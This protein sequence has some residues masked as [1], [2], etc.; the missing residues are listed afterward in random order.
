MPHPTWFVSGGVPIPPGGRIFCFSA[1]GGDPRAFLD[2]QPSL[3]ADAQIMA[4]CLPGRGPRADEPAPRS[5]AELADGAA[6]AISAY[7]DRPICL[8]GHSFGALVAFEVA[9]RL[10]GVS[11][12]VHHLV[13]SG[14]AA[15]SLLPTDY[16]VWAAANKGRAFLDESARF[17]ELPPEFTSADED[18]QELLLSDFRTDLVLLAEYSYIRAAP[19]ALGVT[20]ICGRDDSYVG[21]D[22]LEPWGRECETDPDELWMDGDH[23]FL[24]KH[25]SA[26]VDVLRYIVRNGPGP[27]AT[28][29]KDVEDVEDVEVI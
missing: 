20:L 6:A 27:A 17:F 4:V 5:I 15:P 24:E 16:N 13:A 26:V 3:G 9:R 29:G 12:A 28:A 22:A 7:T 10:G 8:F 2:W 23:F 25:P 19:L 14:C 11:P 21:S 1:A 18:V